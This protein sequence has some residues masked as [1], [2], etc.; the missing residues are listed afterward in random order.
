MDIDLNLSN[1]TISDLERFFGVDPNYSMHDV[2][3]KEQELNTRLQAITI[4]T[5][6]KQDIL[7]FLKCAKEKLLNKSE[8]IPKKTDAFI[9]SN[10]SDYFKGTINPIEK[11][12]I[13]KLVCID[14]NKIN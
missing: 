2:E 1:Y 3:R 7:V 6:S 8:I 10:P 12:L 14:T 4:N 13:Q 11:R 5:Q 9:Y